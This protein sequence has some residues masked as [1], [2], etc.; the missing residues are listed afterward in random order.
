METAKN[1]SVLR[2][3]SYL[4]GLWRY[5]YIFCLENHLRLRNILMALSLLGVK[6]DSLVV[7][8]SFECSCCS[9]SSVERE[10]KES[11]Y[12]RH[13]ICLYVFSF[14][15]ILLVFF[16]FF[17]FLL[18]ERI[19][20]IWEFCHIYPCSSLVFFNMSEKTGKKRRVLERYRFFFKIFVFR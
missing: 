2:R 16:I 11:A 12:Q 7:L 19:T 1:E 20:F 17:L 3:C 5:E 10:L 6:I 14:V 8:I 15:L 13:N 4:K 18:L 9:S